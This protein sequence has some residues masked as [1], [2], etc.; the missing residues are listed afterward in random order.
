[1]PLNKNKEPN[2]LPARYLDS[3]LI[4]QRPTKIESKMLRN[5]FKDRN[6]LIKCPR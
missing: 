1:M 5:E 2:N 6:G 3:I 4:M